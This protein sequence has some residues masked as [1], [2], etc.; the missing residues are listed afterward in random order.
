MLYMLFLSL[1]IQMLQDGLKIYL[2]CFLT[3]SSK[4]IIHSKLAI[5]DYK[6]NAG[7]KTWINKRR[8]GYY[9]TNSL[10]RN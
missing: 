2:D 3:L 1:P 7:H 6:K 4:F 10:C 9:R 5:P 8:I